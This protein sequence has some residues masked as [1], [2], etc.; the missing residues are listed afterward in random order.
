MAILGWYIFIGYHSLDYPKPDA[1]ATEM[2]R[3][4]FTTQ[5]THIALQSRLPLQGSPVKELQGKANLY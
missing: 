1:G 3:R 4:Q 5:R 2:A